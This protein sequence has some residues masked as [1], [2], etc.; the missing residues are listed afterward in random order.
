VYIYIYTLDSVLSTLWS[1]GDSLLLPWILLGSSVKT[2]LK[3]AGT[4][5]RLDWYFCSHNYWSQ[6][7]SAR[8]WTSNMLHQHVAPT[9]WCALCMA[10]MGHLY[11][12][13]WH[14]QYV[15]LEGH[16]WNM[17]HKKPYTGYTNI[18]SQEFRIWLVW[19]MCMTLRLVSK[20]HKSHVLHT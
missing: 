18:M 10:L 7:S 11:N 3:V 19:V 1:E 15:A 9:C 2:C 4:Q 5:W 12:M 8:G 16:V 20:C 17:T 13:M 6:I 14:E